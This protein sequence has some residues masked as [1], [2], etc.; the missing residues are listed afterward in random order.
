MAGR[1]APAAAIKVPGFI[2][3]PSMT[4]D[5]NDITYHHGHVAPFPK[6]TTTEAGT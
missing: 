1:A 2:G 3:D 6:T 4:T 5:R